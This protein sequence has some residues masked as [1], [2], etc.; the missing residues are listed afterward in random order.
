MKNTVLQDAK[1]LNCM[2][3]VKIKTPIIQEVCGKD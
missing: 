3:A 1:Q 2:I